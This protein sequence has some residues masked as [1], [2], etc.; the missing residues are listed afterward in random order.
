MGSFDSLNIVTG[1]QPQKIL[2]VANHG[3]TLRAEHKPSVRLAI[4]TALLDRLA[5]L[6]RHMI[7][8]S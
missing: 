6:N 3:L 7:V 4:Y 1:S 8:F 2:S 5:V